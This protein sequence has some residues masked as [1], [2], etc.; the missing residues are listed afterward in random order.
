ML[1]HWTGM[2]KFSWSTLANCVSMPFLS[3]SWS[4]PV[5]S[6]LPI[7]FQLQRHDLALPKGYTSGVIKIYKVVDRLWLWGNWIINA[8]V[9]VLLNTTNI[10][11]SKFCS[12]E[13]KQTTFQINS[14]YH[15][16]QP[17][18]QNPC[19]DKTTHS[20][21]S[22]NLLGP[23]PKEFYSWQHANQP[24]SFLFFILFIL[25]KWYLDK[26]KYS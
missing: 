7:H 8:I 23:T 12:Q 10:Y 15:W 19:H 24:R 18:N 22:F 13:D 6:Q 21:Q 1:P 20:T 11:A 5:W 16:W 4:V 3:V 2:H 17:Q 14:L 9:R 25:H 26:D